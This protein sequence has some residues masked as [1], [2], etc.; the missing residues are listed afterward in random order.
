MALR[1]RNA[2]P[3]GSPTLNPQSTCHGPQPGPKRPHGV[4]A[5][6]LFATEPRTREKTR[7]RKRK[8]AERPNNTSIYMHTRHKV[9]LR[10]VP[11]EVP[12]ERTEKHTT[13]DIA[14]Y[15]YDIMLRPYEISVF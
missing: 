13:C 10:D 3:R 4:R 12:Q 8:N 2:S 9:L 15:A 5:G 1:D 7:S 6:S 11:R 14:S